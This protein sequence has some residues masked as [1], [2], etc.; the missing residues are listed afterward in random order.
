[1]MQC[2]ILK[3]H[4]WVCVC[5][6]LKERR[7]RGTEETSTL[8]NLED[9]GEK[10]FEYFYKPAEPHWTQKRPNRVLQS[11]DGS[12]S[13]D[14]SSDS[15]DGTDTTTDSTTD[16]SSSSSCT[17]N[18]LV[19]LPL[20]TSLMYCALLPFIFLRFML[21]TFF[22]RR[23]E[24]NSNYFAKLGFFKKCCTCISRN[25]TIPVRWLHWLCII[26]DLLLV[27]VSVIADTCE[28]PYTEDSSG[29]LTEN[30]GA[31]GLKIQTYVIICID[32]TIWF[33]L[34][35]AFPLSKRRFAPL[36]FEFEPIIYSRGKCLFVMNHL[37][38]PG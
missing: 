19:Y 4:G 22:R 32:F 11:S 12:T 5:F 27:F 24:D 2:S 29:N 15:T 10:G 7:M 9:F 18:I 20:L 3:F 35:F 17:S 28:E 38:G 8:R 13:S 21:F 23:Y 14:A 16:T 30:S 26:P 1:M 36:F 31:V 25:I 34:H 33:L 37:L 6:K